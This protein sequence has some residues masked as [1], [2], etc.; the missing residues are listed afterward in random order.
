MAEVILRHAIFCTEADY[1]AKCVWSRDFNVGLYLTT[2]GFPR[3]EVQAEGETGSVRTRRTLIEP[4]VGG[5]PGPLKKAIGDKLSYVEEAS[6]DRTKGVYEFKVIP[7]VFADKAKVWGNL[8][9]ENWNG[10]SFTRV[11]RIHVE[12]KVFGVGGMVEERIMQDL[13]RSYDVGET[14]TND[15]AAAGGFST[16]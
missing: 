1:W 2:L 15:F 9:C 8:F 5:L 6:F 14:W 10:K 3:Y 16:R 4:P 7:S 12:V 11:S 13:R